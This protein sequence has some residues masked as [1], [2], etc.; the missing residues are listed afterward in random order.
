MFKKCFDVISTVLVQL[1]SAPFHCFPALW[2]RATITMARVFIENILLLGTDFMDSAQPA[3]S[4]S[5]VLFQ[6]HIRILV[7]NTFCYL[8][9]QNEG[10]LLGRVFSEYTKYTPNKVVNFTREFY[11]AL[12][13]TAMEIFCGLKR[14]IGWILFENRRRIFLMKATNR[15]ILFCKT[16]LFYFFKQSKGF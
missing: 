2:R 4:L 14:T 11:I 3:V 16:M 15:L 5:V 9:P 6:N 1:H 10:H 7:I 13:C 12:Q 8:F